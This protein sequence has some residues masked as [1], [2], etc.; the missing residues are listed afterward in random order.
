MLTS[1]SENA[2][3]AS[4]AASQSAPEP[5]SWKWTGNG[6]R[7]VRP[8]DIQTGQQRAALKGHTSGIGDLDFSSD[9]ETLVSAGLD[10]TVRIW[11]APRE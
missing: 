8:W 10:R 5:G 9:G 1:P 4:W 11:R 7:V 6:V 2:N 3:D